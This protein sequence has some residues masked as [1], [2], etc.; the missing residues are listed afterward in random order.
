MKKYF[1]IMVALLLGI[2]I[3][4]IP[5]NVHAM[6]QSALGGKVFLV[7]VSGDKSYR[8]NDDNAQNEMVLIMF[9]K[10]GTR[11]VKNFLITDGQGNITGFPHY[12]KENKKEYNSAIKSKKGYYKIDMDMPVKDNDYQVKGNKVK[13]GDTWGNIQQN[14]PDDYIIAWDGNS[15]SEL[16]ARAAR[17]GAVSVEDSPY[18]Q[19]LVLAN[20]QYKFKW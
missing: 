4:I 11:Y 7:D 16:V 8:L 15:G 19:H 9:N 18:T 6:K 5:T 17:D 2:C 13:M 3:I 20:Q 14:E 10:K 1:G 12:P